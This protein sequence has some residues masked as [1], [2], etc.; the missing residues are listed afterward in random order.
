MKYIR[1]F[2]FGVFFLSACSGDSKETTSIIEIEE[3]DSGETGTDTDS[4]NDEELFIEETIG[5]EGG[6]L[7]ATGGIGAV[8]LEIPAGALEADVEIGIAEINV[9]DLSTAMGALVDFAGGAYVFTPHGTTFGQPV[10]I[11]LPQIGFADT[12]LRLEDE[13][14]M[15]WEMIPDAIFTA[16]TA[17]FQTSTFSIYI[18]AN[19]CNSYCGNVEDLC[20]SLDHETCLST[21]EGLNIAG[22][23]GNCSQES[24][25]NYNC[26]TDAALTASDFDCSNGDALPATCLIT[27]LAASACAS[28]HVDNDGDGVYSD[29]DCND[30]DDTIYLGSV[31]VC[32][33]IDNNCDGQVDEGLTTTYYLDADS[34]GFGDASSTQDACT[35]PSGYVTDDTDCDDTTALI[36]PGITEICDGI[37]NN[38][39]AQAD[40]GVT[41]TYYEDGDSDDF[42]NVSSTREACS[43][44]P[45]Y[46]LDSTD[47]DDTHANIYPGNVEICD[48]NDNNCDGLL[49]EDDPLLSD[50]TMFYADADS[51]SFGDAS[52]TQDACTQPLGYVA[53]STDCNDNDNTINLDAFDTPDDGID[54]DCSGS[55][56]ICVIGAGSWYMGYNDSGSILETTDANGNHN[57]SNGDPYG[58]MFIHSTATLISFQSLD[59]NI[60]TAYPQSDYS[61]VY[62]FV[63]DDPAIDTNG[64]QAPPHNERVFDGATMYLAEHISDGTILTVD[65]NGDIFGTTTKNCTSAS[66]TITIDKGHE[67]ITFDMTYTVDTDSDG[68]VSLLDCDDSDSSINPG[69]TEIFN[70]GIDQDCFGSDLTDTDLDG[71]RSDVDCDDSDPSINPGAAEI[72]YDG[73]DQNCDGHSDFDQDQDGYESSEHSGSCNNNSFTNRTDCLSNNNNNNNNN[74]NIWTLYGNCSDP[75]FLNEISCLANLSLWSVIATD[76]NDL[77]SSINTDAIETLNDGIDQDC[78]GVAD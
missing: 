40:E 36:N 4:G 37:D 10:E 73:V 50:A 14:D 49:D 66:N 32:D 59:S 42:G 43:Q 46:V 69:A 35:Q 57:D 63:L 70:D 33:T 21:C 16:D 18:I 61:S 55:D 13:Y 68:Y 39:D 56:T 72:W 9:E 62:A 6:T 3:T 20:T 76:C 26:L 53:D 7:E 67:V 60:Q 38:C 41:T 22:P 25:D 58:Y 74:N 28:G 8:I 77:D 27:Q 54:Q 15:S 51:D 30:N 78:D 23:A 34:D 65:P 2:S 29:V 17:S 24:H 75:Y 12:I 47:C 52:S 11:T 44:S 19:L 31:E 48:G 5:S 45:G 64:Y 71:H 1:L